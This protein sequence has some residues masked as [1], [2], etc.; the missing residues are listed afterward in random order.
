[1]VSNNFILRYQKVL[2]IKKSCIVYNSIP[3]TFIHRCSLLAEGRGRWWQFPDGG[4]LLVQD[5][6]S[7]E[8]QLRIHVKTHP[9]HG[10]LE[11]HGTALLEG[12]S[13][14]LQD[15]KAL[16]VRYEYEKL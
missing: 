9:E 5:V 16:R 4:T 6:D 12:D 15:L 7:S 8:D 2:N 3:K 1:M 13:F 14:S 10:R 11:L